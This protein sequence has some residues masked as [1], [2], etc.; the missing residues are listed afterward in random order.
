MKYL[1]VNK[2]GYDLIADPLLNKGM[3]FTEEERSIFKLHGLIPPAVSNIEE[4]KK[5]CYLA[6]NTKSSPIEK[7]IYLSE[8]KNSNETL[9][10]NLVQT[11][12]EEMLPII[13]TPTVGEGCL[14]FSQ[15][16]R[17]P[18]GLFLSYTQ[19]HRMD[20]ILE[21]TRLDGVKV[22]VASDG[23]R[24]LG[25]GDQGAG[26]MGIT[27]GKLSLYTA[28]AG[29]HPSKTLP[30]LLDVGTDNEH[31]LADPL[32]LGSRHKRL[33]GSDYEEFIDLFIYAIKK[34]FPGVLLHWEDFA[35]SNALPLLERYKN[36]VC[37]FNDDIQGTASIAVGVVLAALATLDQQ[38]NQQKI[39]IV[40][41]G[42]A[43]CGIARLFLEFMKESGLEESEALKNLI[44]VDKHGVLRKGSYLQP[45]QEVFAKSESYEGNTLLEVV[46]K[47]HPSILIGVSGQGGIFQEEVVREM[48]LYVTHPIILPLSNPTQL[49][50]ATPSDL[51]EWTR[52]RALIGTGSPFPCIKKEGKDFRVDQINN[53]YVFPGLGLGVLASR[54]LQVTDRMFM[55]AAKALAEMAPAKNSSGGNFLPPLREIRE[56]SFKI[57][58]AV[59]AEAVASG[60]AP[61][62]SP[63]EIEARV[64]EEMWEPEY[65]CY[66]KFF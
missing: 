39:V 37:S 6:F 47:E 10:Y 4:Q 16:Y 41:A 1:Q 24:I 56:V 31:L 25:L 35:Q 3:A 13:Y 23:E 50:E 66:K 28:C 8:L 38:L 14:R 19:R 58:C 11:Y 7:Y 12:I 32:Y 17:R 15:I 34:R 9:F 42:S 52:G 36:V 60:V 54:A 51:M 65:I 40:G 18:R 57:A 27:I 46:K 53:A 26:G 49:S 61:F 59:A 64:K 2:E 22:I 48:A 29:I 45:F 63:S 43:G 20:E 5:R 55:V 30:V 33:R 44:L 21:S 62:L